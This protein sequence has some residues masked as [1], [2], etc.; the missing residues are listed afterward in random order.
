MREL[1]LGTRG[2]ALALWQ[3]RH[4]ASALRAIEPGRRI[5]ERIIKT[6]GDSQQIAPLGRSDVGV[7]VRRIEQALL[8]REIDLAVHSMKDLPTRQ[9][10]GLT[11]ASV[12]PRHDPRD[13]LLTIDGAQLDE[14]P[15]GTLIGTGSL[16]RR[17][18]LLHA[19]PDLGTAPLRG[20]VDTRL[21]KLVAGEFGAVVLAIAGIER[22]GLDRVPYRKLPVEVC[23]PA[24]GQGALA[25]ETRT[26]DG[27]VRE[28][29]GALDDPPSRLAVE[30][31]R[32]FLHELGGGCLAPAT[33]YATIRDGRIDLTAVVGDADGIELLRDSETGAS[34]AAREIGVR[35]ARR[36]K[37]AGAD[38]LLELS[39]QAA[40]DERR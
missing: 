29:V 37:R 9:P 17:T 16:R 12:P 8:A 30:A 27:E 4:V 6:A 38:R 3:A 7:F 11:I 31:E 21:A 1:V 2:S 28:L 10:D 26:E 5:V 32:A 20:N 33:S 35:L 23:L 36:M 22:L 19:R 14:L 39:R 40:G 24:V 25:I 34:T 13:A 15:A 18:Q